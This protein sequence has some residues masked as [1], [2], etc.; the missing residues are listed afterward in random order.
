[1]NHLSEVCRKAL[2][3]SMQSGQEGL[4][5]N[6]AL[7]YS[8]ENFG[9]YVSLYCGPAQRGCLG[10]TQP[11][12]SV[13]D[14]AIKLCIL[15][16]TR[17]DRF[18]P[19]TMAEVD[20]LSIDIW[21]IT[22]QVE[23]GSL[24]EVDFSN[25]GVVIKHPEGQATLLP[26]FTR[27]FSAEPGKIFEE[28]RT[29][30][31]LSAEKLMSARVFRIKTESMNCGPF[32]YSKPTLLKGT[33]KS[34]LALEKWT[35]DF[36]ADRF[37]DLDFPVRKFE[38]PGLGINPSKKMMKVRD[39]IKYWSSIDKDV[40]EEILYFA[41]W[42]YEKDA[43]SLNEDFELPRIFTNDLMDLLPKNLQY[44]R[45]W[46]FFG[47]QHC[48]TPAHV[49][50]LFTSAWLAMIAGRKKVRMVA[51]EYATYFSNLQDLDCPRTRQFVD[52][53]GI[54]VREEIIG[55]GDI[56]F[57]PGGW[58]HHVT[59]LE[60]N[61]LLTGNFLDP[62]C[63]DRFFDEIMQKAGNTSKLAMI[64]KNLEN[65]MEAALEP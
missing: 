58:L 30:S 61:I 19:V 41:N 38:V 62:I 2:K 28:L 12:A 17:D 40:P 63:K 29:K 25:Y 36:F 20:K 5:F 13:Q 46:L 65:Q 44:P 45:R 51:P 10:V 49:D 31:K 64:K 47:H 50:T 8:P 52:E 43:A 4:K 59:S 9:L 60:P 3:A 55:P 14:T 7:S 53:V 26:Y 1:M 57:I 39:Y 15:S 54:P 11:V 56:L 33:A 32:D 37:G 21:L 18:A 22:E 35:P 24:D 23:V 48:N 34:W 16:A 42:L 27:R 6:A